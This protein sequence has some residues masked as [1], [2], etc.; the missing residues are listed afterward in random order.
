MLAEIEDHAEQAI[1]KITDLAEVHLPAIAGYLQQLRTSPLQAVLGSV[2]PGEITEDGKTV[3]A[4]LETIWDALRPAAA[5]DP[6]SPASDG[7]ASPE[8]GEPA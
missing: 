4:A 7:S 2:L 1:A 5:P 6:P 3:L 8:P